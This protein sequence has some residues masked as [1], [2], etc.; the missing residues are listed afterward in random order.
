[1]T[2]GYWKH[3][4]RPIRFALVVD[5]LGVKYVGREHIHHLIKVLK[6]DYEIEVEWEGTQYL[7]I[8]LN[9]DYKKH[10]VHLSMPSYVEQALVRFGHEIPKILQHQP[11]KH[12]IPTYGAMVQYAKPEDS[13][14]LLS[15]AEKKIVQQVLGTFLY[16]GRAVDST[17]LTALS[18]IAS[19]QAEPTQE[20]MENIKL[21][22]NYAASNQDA[23]ITYNASNMI[24]A[25]HSNASYL[26]KPKG[27]SRAGGHFFMSSDVSDPKDNGAVLNIAQ[28]IKAVMSSAAEAELGALYIN[29]HK[30]VPQ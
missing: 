13:T 17:M 12:T 22:L 21:F 5:D 29:A 2:P 19:T 8:T 3:E 9:W 15:K 23:I 26:S 28:L 4:W 6:S 10:Q 18:S 7:G 11:Q 20:T 14:R 27:Q 16:Y 24:L 25:I 30:A 1:M